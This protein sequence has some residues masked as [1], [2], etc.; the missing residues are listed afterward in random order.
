MPSGSI[1]DVVGKL[2][3]GGAVGG[4]TGSLS[5]L[6]KDGGPLHDVSIPASDD[7]LAGAT[8]GAAQ[9]DT[10]GVSSTVQRLADG[11]LPLV[12]Q[13]PGAGDVIRPIESAL[14]LVEQVAGGD[15]LTQLQ[16]LAGRVT[17]E[18]G[19]SREGGFLGTLE[20]LLALVQG[21]DELR[22][23]LD[24]IRTLTGA[25]GLD[26]GKAGTV[27]DAVPAALNGA[28]AL[29]ALM[30]LESSLAEAERLTAVMQDQLSPSAVGTVV[31]ALE[32]SFGAEGASLADFVSGI[33]LDNGAEVEAARQAIQSASARLADVDNLLSRSLG[34]GEATL[35]HLDV[36]TVREEVK[37]AAALL[38]SVDPGPI[39]AA[40]Q[41]LVDALD[42]VLRITPPQ[43]PA[44]QLDFLLTFLHDK[45]GEMADAIRA[46]DFT[47]LTAPIT[48][49]LGTVT[50]A[51]GKV[52]ETMASVVAAIRG[53]LESVRQAVAAL[54]FDQITSA[55]QTVLAP[56]N[57]VMDFIRK[58]VEG[59][60]AALN[61][62]IPPVKGAFATAETA[63]KQ[64]KTQALGLL[65]DAADFIDSLHLDQVAGGVAD[66]VRGLANTLAQ[67]QMTPYFDTAV[68]VIGTTAD[69]FQALPLSLLPDSIKQEVDAAAAP[70][71]AID[72]EQLKDTVEGWFQIG[73]DGKFTLR[74]P[75]ED[76]L[77]DLQNKY[78]ALIEGVKQANPRKAIPVIDAE[79]AKIGGA[80]DELVPKLSLK[81]VQDAIDQVKG[82]L[83]DFDLHQILQPVDA[84]FQQLLSAVDQYSPA[85]LIAPL[86]ERVDAVRQQLVDTVKLDQW[87][88]TLDGLVGQAKGLLA[89]LDVDLLKVFTG[90]LRE[91]N[92]L[93]QRTPDFR[94]GSAF[95]SLFTSL[96]SGTGLRIHPWTFDVVLGWLSGD[97]GVA[98]LTGRAGRTAAAVEATLASVRAL[99]L[100]GL[101][102][103]VGQKAQGLRAAVDGLQAGAAKDQLREALGALDADRRLGALI[104]NRARYLSLL[105]AAAADCNSLRSVGLSQVDVA[106]EG[107]GSAFS[108]LARVRSF[109]RSLFRALG[110]PNLDASLKDVVR[111]ILALLTP[112]RLAEIFTPILDAVRARVGGL[113]DLILAPIQQAITH[114]KEIVDTFD[115]GPLRE[116]LEAVYQ[117]IRAGIASL[118]PS[119]VLQPTLASFDAL[120]ADLLAFDP[121]HPFKVLIDD[122]VA[123]AHRVLDSLS[124]EELLEDPIRIYDDVVAALEA[125]NLQNLLAPVLDALDSIA[126]QV[127][128]GLDRTAEALVRLQG[129]LP[130]GGGSSA[131][132]SIEVG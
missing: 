97:S 11:L 39:R 58:L 73:P 102:A 110:I 48:Q 72:V 49:G 89:K 105:E 70:I 91:A 9:V 119:Q 46:L 104:A 107:L 38:S 51:V 34:F 87:G 1:T 132:A 44:V 64:F 85:A 95:G 57:A 20:R 76:A 118:S 106:M 82:A 54:P 5:D 99:D 83:R 30:A 125:L 94:L 33:H 43:G 80:I 8:Q 6:T 78:T 24:L 115:L 53:A 130:S 103:R 26:L 13:I 66:N 45:A 68:D 17:T 101:S 121:L 7:Q 111:G 128:T 16:A 55:V 65:E 25:S 41:G 71:R 62:V 93:F 117:E 50:G 81:P 122:L 124:G 116:G 40:V 18:L 4:L 67:A 126:E 79:L 27:L 32:A 21:A 112:E 114:L 84:A 98:A 42:P 92:A 47:P 12:S 59:I 52:A 77:V 108:P 22:A 37:R 100:A 31:G 69:V 90:A 129:A 63:I 10:S 88:P 113:L 109:I 28:R 74:K 120:K 35:V 2:N 96:F 61:A 123:T 23:L 131:S 127:D 3:L 29:G 75:I 36:A 19:G 86:E 56:V 60:G 15:L 14:A